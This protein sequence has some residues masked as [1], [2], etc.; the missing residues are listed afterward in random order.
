MAP[1]TMERLWSRADANARK[2]RQRAQRQKPRN[3]LRPAASS[4]IRLLATRDS[5]EG[6]DGSSPSESFVRKALQNGLCWLFVSARFADRRTWGMY[7]AL[8]GAFR[9]R[10]AS[11]SRQ[12]GAIRR[13]QRSRAWS[14]NAI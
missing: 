11:R 2:S 8:Y 7:G 3:Y 5:E 12:K 1:L 14:T 6:V 4:C 13:C 9:S 10:T